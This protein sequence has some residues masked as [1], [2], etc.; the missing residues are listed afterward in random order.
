MW[1][2]QQAGL[3]GRVKVQVHVCVRWKV[4]AGNVGGGRNTERTSARQARRPWPNA[5]GSARAQRAPPRKMASSRSRYA[6]EEEKACRPATMSESPPPR[7]PVFAHR[8]RLRHMSP[9]KR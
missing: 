5:V 7:G 8:H 9:R 6:C 4:M 3:V 2:S 1:R